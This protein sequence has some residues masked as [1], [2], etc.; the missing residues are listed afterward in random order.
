V[1]QFVLKRPEDLGV[2]RFQLEMHLVVAATPALDCVGT[3][4]LQSVRQQSAS[5]RQGMMGRRGDLR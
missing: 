3:F 4:A 1:Q 2:Q 5:L